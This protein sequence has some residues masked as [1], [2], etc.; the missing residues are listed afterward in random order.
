MT[1]SRLKPPFR[2]VVPKTRASVRII[3]AKTLTAAVIPAEFGVGLARVVC[4]LLNKD[5]NR[6]CHSVSENPP[7][8]ENHPPT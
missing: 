7:A 8:R 1:G 5:A 2:V 3:D 6:V 4:D